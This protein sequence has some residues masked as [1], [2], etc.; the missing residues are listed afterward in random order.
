[1]K[2]IWLIN[3]PIPLIAN[4]ANIKMGGDIG[5]ISS[6]AEMVSK[7]EN[8]DLYI[9]FPQLQY[10]KTIQGHVSRI[11]YYGFYQDKKRSWRQNKRVYNI[12][13]EILKIIEPDIIHIWGTEFSQSLDMIEAVKDKDKIIVHIQGLVSV[14]ADFFMESL[15]LYIKYGFTLRDFLRN[16]NILQAKGKFAKRGINEKII[17]SNIKNVIGRTDWDKA[18]V[19]HINPNIKYFFCREAVRSAFFEYTWDYNKMEPYTIFMTQGNYPIKG[20]HFI[21]KAMAILK[22]EYPGI[23]LYVAG[24]NIVYKGR[25]R[26]RESTYGYYIRTLI[27]K[28]QLNKNVEFVGFQDIKGMIKYFLKANVFALSSVIENSPNSLAEAQVLGVP[29]VAADVGG[30]SSMVTHRK[31]CL[32]YQHN[33]PI[34]LAN[35]IRDVFQSEDLANCLS[36]SAKTNA[37]YNYNA[38]NVILCLQDIYENL[39]KN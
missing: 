24:E 18:H 17:L 31:D 35:Y 11:N 6:I 8:I 5:W 16:D 33:D 23:K 20:F 12:F 36:D 22:K 10:K 28:Y 14:C 4:N 34:M 13:T 25:E 19:R 29:S 1:M 26:L 37:K 32:I 7:I 21:L 9:L 15:P 39:Y 38:D 30:I 2:V 3:G 27:A